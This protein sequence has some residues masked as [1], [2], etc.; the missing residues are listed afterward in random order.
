MHVRTWSFTLIVTV[1]STVGGCRG[2]EPTSPLVTSLRQITTG[3]PL[4]SEDTV[5]KDVRAFYEQRQGLPAW[6][7][8][9]DTAKVLRALDVLRTATRHGFAPEDYDEPEIAQRIHALKDLKDDTPEG[10]RQLA[11]LDAHL[12]TALLA[13]GRDVAVGR[14]PPRSI[15]WQWK[16]RRTAPDLAGTLVRATGDLDKWL[17]AIRPQHP[18]YAALQDALVKLQG[19]RDKG[20]WAAVPAAKF[21]VGRAS[22]SVIPLRQRLAAGGH[23]SEAA[24]SKTSPEY[25]GDEQ[26]AVQAFQNLH[27]LPA[28]GIADPATVAAM[29]VPIDARIRQ[30][31]LNLERWRWMPDDLGARHLLVNIPYYH[32]IARENGKAVK[33]IR[34]VVGKTTN[35]TPIFSSEMST[36]V[37]SPYWNIPDSIVEGETAPAVARDPA[38]LA[39]N[40]IEILDVSDSGRP[41]DH[42][43][44]DWDDADQ[45][46]HLV[47]RQRPGPDNA[48]GHVKFLFPNEFE[49][50]L[51]DTPADT[52][53]ARPGRAF[54]HGCVRIEEP[55]ALAKYVLTGHSEWDDERILEAMHSGVEKHVKLRETIPV[56]IVYFTAWVDEKGGLHFQQD[57]YGYDSR[58]AAATP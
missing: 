33:D 44:V 29:N 8:G 46:E 2:V 40:N 18:E 49:V 58:Q 36:I 28:T 23:L 13:L 34:V 42:S 25:S 31:E 27:A 16:S 22:P 35:K 45:L 38:Y 50:Y 37:F 5:W 11:E 43:S 54:S 19:Q 4:S 24:A 1:A 21:T 7:D 41:V 39:K 47:F 56:H 53:F 20:G 26:K 30:V 57:V 55:E 52:L 14:T 15:D 12:T 32:L 3:A 51:H 6:V 48:L 17:D 10:A 9:K